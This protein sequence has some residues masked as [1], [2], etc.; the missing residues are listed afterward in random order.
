MT[1]GIDSLHAT[2]REIGRGCTRNRHFPYNCWGERG[3]GWIFFFFVTRNGHSLL[4]RLGG[5]G[6]R[7]FYL[8]IDT[9]RIT[10]G[11]GRGC[12]RIDSL[13]TTFGESGGGCVC[14]CVWGGGH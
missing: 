9:L 11:G 1:P 5:G 10:V 3:V 14:V 4:G 6:G 13:C 8:G 7:G 2:V 12:I